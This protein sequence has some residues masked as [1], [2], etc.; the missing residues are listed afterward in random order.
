[1]AN[2]S[3][4][5]SKRNFI[6]IIMPKETFGVSRLSLKLCISANTI[7]QDGAIF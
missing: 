7:A 5:P 2:I 1:M 3:I 4:G 6:V